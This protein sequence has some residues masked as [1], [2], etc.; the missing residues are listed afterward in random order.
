MT[1]RTTFLD[2]EFDPRDPTPAGLLS[3]GVTDDAGRDYYAV[4]AGANLS[5]L[6][7]HA[8]ICDHVLPYLPVTVT[9]D[10]GGAPTAITWDTGHPHY[11]YVRS[12]QEIAHDLEGYFD[13]PETPKAVAYFGAQDLCRLHAMWDSDWTRMPERVPR[14]FTDLKVMAD[15]LGVAKEELPAHEGDAHHALADARW[16]RLVHRFL[17][18]LQSTGRVEDLARRLNEIRTRAGTV[19]LRW[20]VLTRRQQDAHRHGA[21]LLLDAYTIRPRPAPASAGHGGTGMTQ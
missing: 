20:E 15:D 21:R 6:L 10:A 8:F 11:R 4:H 16:N 3:L 7:D 9:R 17:L 19:P 12:A 13:G 1:S 5:G 2:C 14:Y 18:S